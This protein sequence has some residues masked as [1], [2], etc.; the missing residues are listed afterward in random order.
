MKNFKQTP[1]GDK[2]KK[3]AILKPLFEQLRKKSR[4]IEI[5]LD[6]DVIRMKY[7]ENA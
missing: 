5:N 1:R 3:K 2:L 4:E 7:F 6:P